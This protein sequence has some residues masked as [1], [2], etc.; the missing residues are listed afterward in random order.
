ME[1]ALYCCPSSLRPSPSVPTSGFRCFKEGRGGEGEGGERAKHRLTAATHRRAEQKVGRNYC[2]PPA[3]PST[4]CARLLY[5]CA[6]LARR[7]CG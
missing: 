3:P 1:F 5:A 4:V 6:L 7:R 2:P